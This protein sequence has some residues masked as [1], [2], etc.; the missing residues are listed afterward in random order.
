MTNDE[1]SDCGI[2][3]Y[4]NIYHGVKS[5]RFKPKDVVYEPYKLS[6]R[7]LLLIINMLKT[8]EYNS[9]HFDSIN[10]DNFNFNILSEYNI[11]YVD[12]IE[13]RSC[14]LNSVIFPINLVG[15]IKLSN[16]N[17]E[18]QGVVFPRQCDKIIMISCKFTNLII[19]G[20]IEVVKA[21]NC[22]GN[23]LDIS[24][25]LV[26]TVT[27]GQSNNLMVLL[28]EKLNKLNLAKMDVGKIR[29]PKDI[30]TLYAH[31]LSNIDPK[32]TWQCR[33]E[34]ARMLACEHYVLLLVG[35]KFKAGCRGPYNYTE[36]LMHWGFREDIRAVK[37]IEA[38]EQ[39]AVRGWIAEANS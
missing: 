8:K 3:C 36:A 24:K 6:S 26:D 5:L 14:S 17:F 32:K 38:I 30:G 1:T 20:N 21:L 25:C 4:M 27:V 31:N 11:G 15:T 9:I 13:M 23:I 33:G 19:Y 37:F 22:S 29:L 10:I 28:P 34:T 2:K 7:D 18:K 16:C 35:T 39:V 12:L